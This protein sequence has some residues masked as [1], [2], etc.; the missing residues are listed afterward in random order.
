[1]LLKKWRLA[2][3]VKH[4]LPE[5]AESILSTPGE[6]QRPSCVSVLCPSAR[7]EANHEKPQ[8]GA[9]LAAEQP[10]DMHST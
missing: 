5:A 8:D 10:A 6:Y 3:D 2:Q 4:R 9:T 7:M 1:M